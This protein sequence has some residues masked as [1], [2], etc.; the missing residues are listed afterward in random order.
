MESST[1]CLCATFD[2]ELK[3][4][5]H[6]LSPAHFVDQCDR[7]TMRSIIIFS[8][9]IN[10]LEQS[11]YDIHEDL[12]TTDRINYA[13]MLMSDKLNKKYLQWLLIK[14]EVEHRLVRVVCLTR[15]FIHI[16]L[17]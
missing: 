13:Q 3:S 14:H 11:V 9:P 8:Q 6:Q 7:L 10:S 15:V 4:A 16:L 17:I 12:N 5:L 1:P 2:V